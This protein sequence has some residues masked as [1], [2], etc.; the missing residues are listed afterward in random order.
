M[1]KTYVHDLM[2]ISRV[3]LLII[4]QNDINPKLLQII[5]EK[6]ED[7]NPKADNGTTPL[8]FLVK[9]GK[10]ELCQFIVDRIKDPKAANIES[11]DEDDETPFT[12]AVKNNHVEIVK[13]LLDK[14]E[15]A[16]P[17]LPGKR[18]FKSFFILKVVHML[19]G[20]GI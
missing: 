7:I 4:G 17:K 18:V 6:V 11:K 19:K 20:Y 13:M 9:S 3:L 15:Y 16:N 5:A 8:H 14:V 10:T 2:T 1:P 12:L